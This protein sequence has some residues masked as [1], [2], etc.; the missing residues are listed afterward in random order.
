M[1]GSRT[2]LGRAE[3]ASI[4]LPFSGIGAEH[5]RVERSRSGPDLRVQDLGSRNGTQVD[6]ARVPAKG[7]DLREGGVLRVGEAVFLYR[8]WSDAHAAVAA[9]PPLPGPVDSCHPLVTDGLRR[10]QARRFDGGS[11]YIAGE[12]GSGRGVVVDHLRALTESGSGRDWITGGA[13]I[14]PCTT[15][16]ADADPTRTLLM[17]PLRER[18]EDLLVLLRALRGGTLPPMTPR[19]IEGMLVYAW[20]G[21]IRE[22]RFAVARAHD[23]RFGA[24]PGGTWDLADFPD[25]KRFLDESIGAQEPLTNPSPQRALPSTE[26]EMRRQL[27]AHGWRIHALAAAAGCTRGEALEQVFMLG[28]REPRTR[29]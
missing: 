6:G 18:G 15:P 8:R 22:L 13:R 20:P 10:V 1:Q 4:R 27:D 12:R 25:V 21:N 17:P 24:A 19:L 9:L 14:E 29:D 23:P 3:S 26:A 11:L 2:T 5:A 28:I 7:A 16:P